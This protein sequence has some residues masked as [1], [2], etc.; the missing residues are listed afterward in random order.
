MND[1]P[2]HLAPDDAPF[3]IDAI[4]I[5]LKLSEICNLACTYCYYYKVDEYAVWKSRPKFM[6]ESIVVQLTDRLLDFV[7]SSRTRRVKIV[8]HGGEPTL[9]SNEIVDFICKHMRIKIGPWSD[10]VFSLQTNGYFLSEAWIRTIKSNRIDV[11]ISID[12]TPDVHDRVRVTQTG[13]PT[14]AAIARTVRKLQV[15]TGR[16]DPVPIGVLTVVN[17]ATDIQKTVKYL[18][19]ELGVDGINFLLECPTSDASTSEVKS[20]RFSKVLR[21]IF[22]SSLLHQGVYSHELQLLYDAIRPRSDCVSASEREGVDQAVRL[23]TIA[24]TVH[25][26]GSMSVDDSLIVV[27]AWFKLLPRANVADTAIAEYLLHPVVRAYHRSLV[28]IPQDCGG[29]K[30]AKV[31]RGGMPHFR[32]TQLRGFENR[33]SYCDSYFEFYEHVV[34]TLLGAG[35]PR[36]RLE[37]ALA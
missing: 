27:I 24:L 1:W 36:E 14:S 4:S 21:D 29:C 17:E 16:A 9:L 8:L 20:D 35:F 22:D 34:A 30:F 13:R 6:D 3:R 18:E 5:V 25:T 10:V 15:P 26:D 2:I 23:P 33:S 32:Y 7:R 11:G 37:T 12:G 28:E 19:E 31:C